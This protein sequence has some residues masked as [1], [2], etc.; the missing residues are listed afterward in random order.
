MS[1]MFMIVCSAVVFGSIG[2][3]SVGGSTLM[4]DEREKDAWKIDQ[5]MEHVPEQPLRGKLFGHEVGEI[6]AHY[7]D[8][9]ITIALKE[10]VGNWP[11]AKL[12]IFVGEDD[13][14]KTIVV[15][16]MDH[17]M[18]PNIHLNVGMEDRTFPGTLMFMEMYAMRLHTER[19]GDDRLQCTIHLSLPDYKKSHIVG[20]FTARRQ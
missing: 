19:V 13:Y 6:E 8:H 5:P 9:A 18:L 3:L 15:T 20:Q 14:G 12:H 10:Q 1:R 11:A 2:V 17:G 16:P 7:N 4:V